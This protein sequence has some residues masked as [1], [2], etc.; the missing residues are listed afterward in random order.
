MPNAPT[1]LPRLVL[2]AA[3]TGLFATDATADPLADFYK[4]KTM[5]IVVGH[6]V[7]TGFD[8]YARVLA[9]HLPR[10]IPGQPNMI[11]QRMLGASGISA[12]N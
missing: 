8:T 12:A 7:G 11:V 10:H 6:E 9:R 3:L 4:G 2:S 1:S 5:S